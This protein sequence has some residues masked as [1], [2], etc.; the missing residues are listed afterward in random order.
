MCF[1]EGTRR[2]E[3]GLF[4]PSLLTYTWATAIERVPQCRSMSPAC[5]N[6]FRL[7][8]KMPPA[9]LSSR[10]IPVRLIEPGT[11][12]RSIDLTELWEG[13]E[14]LYFLTW[15]DIRVRYTQALLGIA[16]AVLVPFFQMV[17]FTVIF[18][19]LA[20]L[21]SDGLPQPVFYYSALLPWTYFATALTLSSQSL[22]SNSSMLTKVY[23]PRM[24]MPM[25]SC[26]AG[27]FDFAIAFVVLVLMMAFYGIGFGV[28]ALLIPFILLIAF[29]TALGTGLFFAALNVKY[30][31]V[32]HVIPFL[33]QAWM[34]CTVIL[35]FSKIPE[36]LGIWR[37]FY[38]L[39]PMACVVE[40]FRWCLLNQGMSTAAGM[41]ES[42][43][44]VAAPGD[45]LWLA[46][47]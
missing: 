16:W 1:P 36:D 34:F 6:P 20:G 2:P 17:I 44:T 43:S 19:K 23:F 24:L 13:R 40:G 10:D 29:M 46:F 39:N 35:P 4:I 28:P 26:V 30:R 7:D 12:W 25:A 8:L 14:L 15:R 45:C 18:G 22:V 41:D 38:G 5:D 32:R 27:L 21:P 31:D 37:Y 3:G 42:L 33:I 9:G 11:G 47:P